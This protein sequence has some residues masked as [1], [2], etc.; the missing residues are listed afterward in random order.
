MSEKK[1]KLKG[2]L[3]AV[4]GV[5]LALLCI[6]YFLLGG[7]SPQ[8]EK[9]GG[10]LIIR[11]LDVGQG[12]S[13]LIS[14]D[15]ENML[16][17]SGIRDVKEYVINEVKSVGKLKIAVAT[18]P[19]S[20]H[21]GA[22]AEVIR[23]CP[24]EIFIMPDKDHTSASFRKMVEAAEAVGADMQY[25]YE[26]LKYTLGEA[27]LTVLSPEKDKYYESVNDYSVVILLEYKGFRALLTGDAEFE[28]E[29]VFAQKI[30]G[31][32]DLFKA[33]HHGGSSSN[34]EAL[35]S[36]IRPDVAVVSCGL[37]NDYG[38]PHRETVEIFE[39]YGV[40]TYRTDLNGKVTVIVDG[41]GEYRVETEK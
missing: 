41:G 36:V 34:T 20:D 14:C 6:L 40:K 28:T 13:I 7:T 25:G 39:K 16:I 2:I 3:S 30:T 8:E 29:K 27:N 26:G 35:M 17:D 21:I 23:A 11:F 10:E 24:P 37:N 15:G 19:H 18:H 31:K 22:M 5:A 9:T 12:D 32:V 38:H 1:S 33:G 4:G